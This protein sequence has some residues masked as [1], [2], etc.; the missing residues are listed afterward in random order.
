MVALFAFLTLAAIAFDLWLDSDNVDAVTAAALIAPAPD[1]LLEV[2]PVSNDVNRVANDNSGLL[3]PV[4]IAPAPPAESA[5]AG[6]RPRR[7]KKNDG[8]GV[9]F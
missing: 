5:P 2:W 9:L 8:Q 3:E 7:E 6:R 1:S 4:A